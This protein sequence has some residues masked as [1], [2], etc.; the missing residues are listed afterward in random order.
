M[1]NMNFLSWIKWTIIEYFC[2]HNE[3]IRTIEYHPEIVD[4][5]E[6]KIYKIECPRCGKIWKEIHYGRMVWTF[7]SKGNIIAYRSKFEDEE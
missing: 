2:D 7:N 6:F 3:E 5:L 4:F 1:N